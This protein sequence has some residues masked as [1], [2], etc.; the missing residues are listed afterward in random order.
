MSKKWIYPLGL[1]IAVFL[2]FFIYKK[3]RVAPTINLNELNLSDLNG[4]AINLESF[5]GQKIALCFGASWCGNC[6]EE[7]NVLKS[8]QTLNLEG[9]EVIVVSD[10]P[11]EKIIRFKEKHSYPFKF[12]KMN[13]RFSEIGINSIPT[14]YII[15]TKL[16][17]K[18]ETVGYLNW[19]DP[20]T[21]KHLIKLME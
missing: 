18:K 9:V 10:E 20:S 14:S 12:L 5:R 1:I 21:L 3:Y 7:L 17:V 13:Q 4:D 15:N 11:L 16:E 6:I 19:E 8:I 2:A